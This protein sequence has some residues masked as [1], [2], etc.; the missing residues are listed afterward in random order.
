MGQSGTR[1]NR[2]IYVSKQK[3]DD[4]IGC[5]FVFLICLFSDKQRHGDSHKIKM[6]QLGVK[7]EGWQPVTPVTVDQ[8]GVYFRHAAAEIQYR[9]CNFYLKL[10]GKLQS[11]S[12]LNTDTQRQHYTILYTPSST[13][14]LSF[15]VSLYSTNHITPSL[16]CVTTAH[17]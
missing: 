9:V 4:L 14:S 2:T 6:H 10:K 3:C 16:A 1:G 13:F 15:F 12:Q 7:V 11:S 5:G 8:V 17:V